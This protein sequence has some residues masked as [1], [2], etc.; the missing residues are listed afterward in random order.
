MRVIVN[1]DDFGL[2]TCVNDRILDL[3]S[4]RRITS[5]TL[6]A[7]APAVEEAVRRVPRGVNCS[8]GV[9]LNLTEFHPLTPQKEM[10]ILG[11]CLDEKGCFAG[12]EFLR[13]AKMTSQLKEEIFTELC[14]QVEKIRSLGVK[15][16]HFDSH[17]HVHTMPALFP[18]LKQLQKHFGIR[19]VRTTW[20]MFSSPIPLALVLK[21]RIWSFAL[22]HCYKTTTTCGFT[23]F[24][25]FYDLARLRVLNQDAVELMVHPGHNQFEKETQLL[26]TDWDKEILFPIQLIN[27][28]DL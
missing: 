8:I 1:A 28:I 6:I 10:G 27:Y 14:L 22:S 21:K 23:S 11:S 9:H 2:N 24:A 19:K 16:S 20:N 15:I 4:R 13:A 17:N 3:M 18:V 12:E 26:N 25:T 5:A 7:N